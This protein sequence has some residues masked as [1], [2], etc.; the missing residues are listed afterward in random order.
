MFKTL[1]IRQKMGYLRVSAD[2]KARATCPPSS[3]TSV[4]IVIITNLAGM[5]NEKITFF[6][7]KSLRICLV[8]QHK[9][10]KI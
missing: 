6:G 9:K 8:E 5:F 7:N 3:A 4:A 2:T 10:C 1:A